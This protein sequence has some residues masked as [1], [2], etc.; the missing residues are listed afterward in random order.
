[1]EL[2]PYSKAKSTV[3]NSAF[4]RRKVYEKDLFQTAFKLVLVKRLN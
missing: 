2:V 4:L 3:N 1:M